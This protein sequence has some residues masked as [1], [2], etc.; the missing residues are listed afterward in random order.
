MNTKPVFTSFEE[1]DHRLKIL[2]LQR[3]IEMEQIKLHVRG[4]KKNIVP[5]AMMG[6]VGKWSKRLLISFLSKKILKKFR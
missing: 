6:G 4:A 2:K 3:Q 1:I 5:V